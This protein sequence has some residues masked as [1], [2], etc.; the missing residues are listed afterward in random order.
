MRMTVNALYPGLLK[1]C[2]D[3]REM[4]PETIA[5][6]AELMAKLHEEW[7]WSN[8]PLRLRQEMVNALRM[9]EDAHLRNMMA[10]REVVR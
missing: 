7:I 3:E 1:G 2:L 10:A 8:T 9:A 5:Q 4:T 6:G